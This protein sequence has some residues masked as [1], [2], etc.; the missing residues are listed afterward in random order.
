MFEAVTLAVQTPLVLSMDQNMYLSMD[1]SIDL[2]MDPST[3]LSMDQGMDQCLW[4]T[5]YGQDVLSEEVL[6]CTYLQYPLLIACQQHYFTCPCKLR[7]VTR[8]DS[9]LASS[10]TLNVLKRTDVPVLVTKPSTPA[11]MSLQG[12][13]RAMLAV[14][15][16]AR[17]LL[18]W[19]NSYLITPSRGDKLF[20]ARVGGKDAAAQVS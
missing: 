3:D 18:K 5:Q 15:H 4:L 10:I 11:P 14:E 12:G 13:L 19:L 1:Q 17:P 2:S 20:L 9:A 6:L 16:T 8:G 7:Q